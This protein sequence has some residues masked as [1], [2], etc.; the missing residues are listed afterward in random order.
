MIKFLK[1]IVFFLSS[2]VKEEILSFFGC[3]IHG[4]TKVPSEMHKFLL[5]IVLDHVSSIGGDILLVEEVF[6][7]MSLQGGVCL[8]IL[9]QDGLEIIPVDILL[10][11]EFSANFDM[12]VWIILQN[13]LNNESEH[14]IN[15]LN[16]FV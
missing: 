12:S 14:L 13:Q 10:I 4:I 11:F 3:F 1:E 9:F 6:F 7:T 15:S 5:E 2:S 8:F 16:G